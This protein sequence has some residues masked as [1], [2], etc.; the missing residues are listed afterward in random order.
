MVG[1]RLGWCW[2]C[3]VQGR[4]S[5]FPPAKDLAPVVHHLTSSEE[6]LVDCSLYP[7][8]KRWVVSHGVVSQ[9]MDLFCRNCLWYFAAQP[10]WC[11]E[12][13]HDNDCNM[14]EIFFSPTGSAENQQGI[15]LTLILSYF[16]LYTFLCKTF[17][18]AT[19]V[20]EID[21]HSRGMEWVEG[22]GFP[23]RVSA[24]WQLAELQG[25]TQSTCR[26]C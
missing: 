2:L 7:F 22:Y 24:L 6:L 9:H 10:K 3:S 16:L 11:R 20:C 19:L 4:W 15:Y 21:S 25:P 1:G 14:E 5:W 18:P 26:I 13:F 23:Q 17:K 8:F 12:C